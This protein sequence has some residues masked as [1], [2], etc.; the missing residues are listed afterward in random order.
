MRRVPWFAQET[1]GPD[2]TLRGMEI[3]VR[4]IEGFPPGTSG[5]RVANLVTVWSTAER[6][7]QE[8]NG[9][10]RRIRDP[11]L[12]LYPQSLSEG[13]SRSTTPSATRALTAER[14]RP[15]WLRKIAIYGLIA[16]TSASRGSASRLADQGSGTQG[17]LAG[18][19]AGEEIL[20]G[21]AGVLERICGVGQRLQHSCGDERDSPSPPTPRT[22]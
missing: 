19:S 13:R 3:T 9:E 5:F 4:Q 15:N 16:M 2:T 12:R 17:D 14:A 6:S 10:I 21:T 11:A 22:G 1:V 7:M 20:E 18:S 8:L